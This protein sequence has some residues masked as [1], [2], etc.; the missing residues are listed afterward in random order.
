M[1]DALFEKAISAID[2]ANAVDPTLVPTPDGP[3]PK[4]LVH[5]ELMTAW[6][7]RLRPDASEALLLAARAQHIRRWESPRS[8]FPEGR[9][10]Y[11]RWRTQLYRF[12]ADTAAALLR[13]AGYGED[14]AGRVGALIRKEL[15]GRD[16]D[17]Q[18]IEDALCL[19]FLELQL[20]DV[21]GKMDREKLIT[22]LRKTWTKM[23]PD[24]RRLALELALPEAERELVAAA[25]A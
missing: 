10:G 15:L 23:S 24:A 17:A 14:V 22:V 20:G 16:P 19:V 7:R 1:N 21:A 5:A 4:E 8:S 9:T 25:L 18:A 2:A 11:L 13:E 12:H 3:R 6:V